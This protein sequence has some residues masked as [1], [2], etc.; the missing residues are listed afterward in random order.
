MVEQFFR[1]ALR[2]KTWIYQ[3]IAYDVLHAGKVPQQLGKG[4]YENLRYGGHAVN[5]GKKTI[6]KLLEI[7]FS[8]SFNKNRVQIEK[9]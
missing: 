5:N 3:A 9:S 4:S 1:F 2:T 7:N 8:Y 6:Q